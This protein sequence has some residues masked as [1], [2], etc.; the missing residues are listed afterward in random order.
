MTFRQDILETP[1]Q[2][3]REQV[4][5][6]IQE[7][8]LVLEL[9]EIAV[10]WLPEVRGFNVLNFRKAARMTEGNKLIVCVCVEPGRGRTSTLYLRRYIDVLCTR[11][12]CSQICQS[13]EIPG[14]AS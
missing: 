13:V 11:K 12:D 14:A 1:S 7:V 8:T 5:D 6:N 3:L 4:V 10:P 9:E 2:Q